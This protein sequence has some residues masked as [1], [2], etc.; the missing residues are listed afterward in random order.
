MQE[1]VCSEDEH[2]ERVP[3]LLPLVSGGQKTMGV[4]EGNASLRWTLAFGTARKSIPVDNARARAF[5]CFN[6]G[7]LDMNS[8]EILSLFELVLISASI[9]LSYSRTI[10]L[11]T[12]EKLT[13]VCHPSFKYSCSL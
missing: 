12:S 9:I 10:A 2:V 1:C 7:C 8:I 4:A 11:Q 6:T 13:L 3:L 5:I